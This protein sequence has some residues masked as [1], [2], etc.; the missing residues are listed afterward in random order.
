MSQE[1][2]HTDERVELPIERGYPIER[3]NEI[4]DRE[5]R[6]K[7]H[8]RPPY[9]MH[10]W[11]AR[12]LGSVFR[13]IC[14]YSLV[15]DPAN[16]TIREPGENQQLSNYTDSNAIEQRIQEVDLADPTALWDYYQKDVQVKD[17]K[18]LDPFM[19]G[20]TSLLES[21]RFGA[22][23]VGNDLNPVA[24]FVTKKE[25]EAG[26][27]EISDLEK[28]YEKVRSEVADSLTE[29]Y[30]TDCPSCENDADVM[31]YLWV[32]ELDC[33]SCGNT[34]SLFKDYRVA[35]GRYDDDD[36]Y[37]VLCPDCESVIKVSD[38]R[39]E[40]SCGE[41]GFRFTP[42]N[43]NSAGTNYSCSDCG[44]Q[45]GVIDAVREQGEYSLRLYAIEYYCS[46]CDDNGLSRSEV[47]GYKAVT[48]NDKK[49]Y[50]K[51]ESEW[52][53]RP[54]LEDYVPS[55]EIPLGILTDSTAFEGSIGG[56][57]AVLRHGFEKWSD[58]FNARQLLCLSELL[59][60]IDDIENENARE[61]LLLAFSD[62]LMFNNIFT[63]YNLQGHK[64]EGIFKQ[65]TFT[66]QKEFVENN[67]WGTKY[68]RGT[69]Q[70]TWQKII[71]AVEWANNPVER[72]VEDGTTKKSPPFG[73][74]I[75][76]EYKLT[77]GDVRDLDY[78]DEFDLVLTD[79]PYYNNL[80][81]SET[82]NYFYVWLRQLL[83]DQYEEFVPEFTPRAESI[84]AN[85]A[86]GKDA[87]SFEQE[88]KQAFSTVNN[89]L[90][91]DG[92]LVFTYHHSDSD[93]WGELLE[94]LCDV[95][96]EVTATY[97]VT[98]D[99]NRASYKISEGESVSFDI[100]IVA[101][102]AGNTE[103]VSWNSLRRRIYRTAKRTR[104]QLEASQRELSRGDIGVMEMGACFREYS[105]HHGKVQ[106][107]GE[108]MS[109]KEVVQEIYGI[110]QEASD[111]GVE[112]VFI[113]LLDTPNPS[114]DDVN[115]LCRGTNAT[116]KELKEMCLYNQN[117]GFE[118]GTWDNE[119]RQAYIQE[120]V[121]GDDSD[122]LSNLDKL[123]F[124][125]YRYE[126]GQ[127]VQNYVD[128][129]GVNED[130]RELAGRLADITGDDTYTRVLGDRDI[131]SY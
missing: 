127:A 124:L 9:T 51:A 72:Y 100:I 68:G 48:E 16:V 130:L 85:P 34:V 65:N 57:H 103:S 36:L 31:Y 79:P 56:G 64:V 92:A 119:K 37:N 77:Q 108:I 18:V 23:V 90:K 19:G 26:S 116:P 129:W 55:Q 50:E 62:S 49:L 20:G 11:W 60:A 32:N 117:N 80:I 52:K 74:R 17:K 111:I 102:P 89:A 128:K 78:E 76:P 41:C 53:D 3:V 106:R 59:R 83:A 28:A 96:F 1:P 87:E 30:K 98:A 113:D 2:Q 122:H 120:R 54:E 21:A 131:T 123:Q 61:Y 40:C 110:I 107:D 8:Y 118:L 33:V 12:R 93:S 94:A 10:K 5:N 114:F 39:S 73:K 97:P 121:N 81:Y 115:K 7:R 84:V 75:D 58:L 63:I 125:R 112:D 46:H 45:Y 67:V 70:K 38:W 104:R 105:K 44:Q 126:K 42:K 47:K 71:K 24:W 43:G 66:P 4:V 88:L 91:S 86:E 69:F 25:L 29:Y 99:T 22:E 6:A 27:T 14:L 13:T 101:R 109:A 35:K 15:S 82:S 95:G